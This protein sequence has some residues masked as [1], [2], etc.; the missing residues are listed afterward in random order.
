MSK[1]IIVEKCEEC[2]YAYHVWAKEYFCKAPKGERRNISNGEEIPKW[3]PLKELR[4]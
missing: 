2:P 3:C 4:K 1:M